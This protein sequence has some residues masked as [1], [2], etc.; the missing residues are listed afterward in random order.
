MPRTLTLEQVKKAGRFAKAE[1]RDH[2]GNFEGFF[3]WAPTGSIL[4]FGAAA[5]GA[6]IV[7]VVAPERGWEHDRDCDCEF[8]IQ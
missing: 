5:G 7:P 8:C 4:F 1:A 3:R 2:E 6:T